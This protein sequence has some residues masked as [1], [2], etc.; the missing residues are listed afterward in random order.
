ME[1]ARLFFT[2]YGLCGEIRG[3]A[4]AT[5]IPAR[6]AAFYIAAGPWTTASRIGCATFSA[7]ETVKVACLTEKQSA[8]EK[9]RCKTRP[10][11]L[12]HFGGKLLVSPGP[13]S[14]SSVKKT[15]VHG[16]HG[17]GAS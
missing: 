2:F 12:I 8:P 14:H 3:S 11:T 13:T 7:V 6:I 1:L 4:S 15:V 17:S 16:P 9:T 5:Y 10:S